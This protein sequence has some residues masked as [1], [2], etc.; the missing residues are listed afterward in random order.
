MSAQSLI[1][2]GFNIKSNIMGK[3]TFIFILGA[4]LQ[5]SCSSMDEEI[6]PAVGIYR[7]HVVGIA[8]PF[9]VIISTDRNDDVVIE[10]PFD[11]DEYY[12]IYADLDINEGGKMDVEINDQQ[13]AV[14]KH[15]RGNGFILN[16]TIQ[17]NYTLECDGINTK[18]KIVGTKI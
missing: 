8:G 2:S 15:L 11:G 17:I 5:F 10:A 3:F 9:D 12:T 16:G 4:M 13:I 6:L 18:Y 7:A 1:L 14:E